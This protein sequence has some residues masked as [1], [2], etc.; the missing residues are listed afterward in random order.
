MTKPRLLVLDDQG[1]YVRSLARAL[2]A[3]YDIVAAG[4]VEEARERAADNI[5]VALVDV[6]LA[7]D[8]PANREGL[9]FVRWLRADRPEVPVIAM[10]AL[11]DPGLPDEAKAAGA[12]VFLSKP[13]RLSELERLLADILGPT[14]GEAENTPAG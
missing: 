8:D 3:R 13:I 5:G 7:E 1:P 6:R 14:D 11:D 2:R 10:S 4:T 9:V 12:A